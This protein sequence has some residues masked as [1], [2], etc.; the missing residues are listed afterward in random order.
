VAWRTVVIQNAARISLDKQQCRLQ[1]GE[2]IYC[3]PLE[4]IV[5]FV[6]ESPEITLS[7]AFM[8]ACQE[9]AVALIS[10][11]SK[12]MP[13]GVMLPF[14][15]HS[16]QSRAGH[17]QLGWSEALRKRLW[18]K[19]V[20]RKILNQAEVL[21]Q[22]GKQSERLIVLAK[23]VQSGDPMNNEAHAARYYWKHCFGA[24]F[25]RSGNDIINAALNYGYA[26]VR[27]IVA[28]AQVSYGLLPAFGIHHHNE[29]N[30]FNL[31]DDMMEA[32]RPFID[33]MVLE[34]VA[35]EKIMLSEQALSKEVRATLSSVG[36][37]LCH[38]KQETHTIINAAEL[39]TQ[40][41]AQ[42]IEGK[43]ASLLQLP[44]HVAHKAV[45]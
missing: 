11:D 24:E 17:M 36:G 37:V 42:A 41:L 26:I 29:L 5:A 31:T 4:D 30:A 3:F 8:S 16:R 34:L 21:N 18:Q 43:S 40:S 9:H 10:C 12:H 39:M 32:F 20:Q 2:N 1:Q 14:H 35:S 27:A 38:I 44:S 13:N 7:H 22:Q 19:V 45:T 33:K 15:P 6:L 23:S 28:R 25:L